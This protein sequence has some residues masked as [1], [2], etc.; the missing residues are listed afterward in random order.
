MPLGAP[1][2]S[3]HDRLPRATLLQT[4]GPPLIDSKSNLAGLEHGILATPTP[5]PILRW[6]LRICL[7]Q[8]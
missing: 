7:G 8:R 5:V 6:I 3:R 4:N 1:T 2:A